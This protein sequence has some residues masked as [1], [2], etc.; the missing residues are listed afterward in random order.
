MFIYTYTVHP[1]NVRRPYLLKELA[2][3]P[4][5]CNYELAPMNLSNQLPT[6]LQHGIYNLYYPVAIGTAKVP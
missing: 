5:Y 2:T 1:E 4:G 6:G 3:I